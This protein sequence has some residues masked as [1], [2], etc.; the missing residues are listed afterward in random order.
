MGHHTPVLR[1][2]LFLTYSPRALRDLMSR[3][4]VTARRSLGQHFVV[5]SSVVRCMADLS[6]VRKGD[7]VVEVGAGLG[8]LTLALLETGAYVLAIEKDAQLVSVLQHTTSGIS[9]IEIVEGDALEIDFPNLLARSNCW[10]LVANLPYNIATPLVLDILQNVLCIKSMIVMLQLELAERLAAAAGSKARGI[11][12]VQVERYGL[13]EIV[14]RVPPHVFIPRPKV[15]SAVLRIDRHSVDRH[16]L[17]VCKSSADNLADR[18]NRA[19]CAEE[20]YAN[21]AADNHADHSKRANH[22]NHAKHVCELEMFNAL[23][24]TSFG[25]RR[26]MLRNSLKSYVPHEVFHSA[27]ID[28]TWRPEM[29][30]LEQWRAL[31]RAVVDN[32]DARCERGECA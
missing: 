20:N 29:L 4:N 26:K 23:L 32:A 9:N 17:D 10:T 5:E 24:R 3:F 25:Q 11:P 1:D 31:T 15:D 21:R 22:A 16:S 28:P 2:T 19:G 8:S 6:A 13:A 14:E 30:T 7:H 12:S 27:D 18:V